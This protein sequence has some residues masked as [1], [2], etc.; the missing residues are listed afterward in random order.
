MPWVRLD[1]KFHGNPKTLAV[2]NAG[3][4]LYVRALSYCGD[5]LTDGW[6]PAGWAREAGGR[7]L[8]G[9]LEDAGLWFSVTGGEHYEYFLDGGGFYKPRIPGPGFFIPD[10]LLMNPDRIDALAR[11]SESERD[12]A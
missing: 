6:V 3:A 12:A 1:D 9:K 10:Y 5:Q 2:G 8:P 7:T 11:I 4:G